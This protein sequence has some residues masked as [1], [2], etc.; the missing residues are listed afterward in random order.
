MVFGGRAA[1]SV[2]GGKIEYTTTLSAPYS[3]GGFVG[4]LTGGSVSNS[5]AVGG[6]LNSDSAAGGFAGSGFGR[7]HTNCYV[8][9][10]SVGRG[11]G[12]SGGFVAIT[13]AAG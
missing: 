2:N 9:N 5:A 12:F 11:N 13:R 4:T 1:Q 10:M 6:S 8:R 3:D 7:N